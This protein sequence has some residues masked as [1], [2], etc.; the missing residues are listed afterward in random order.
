MIRWTFLFDISARVRRAHWAVALLFL[1]SGTTGA[2]TA[3]WTHSPPA[4]Q[5]AKPTAQLSVKGRQFPEKAGFGLF[6]VTQPPEVLLDGKAARLAPG[7]R[8]YGTDNLL[9][10]SG[11]LVGKTLAVAYVK[12]SYGLLHQVWLLTDAER[13]AASGAS[14]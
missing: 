1:A 7:A 4:H 8:I 5:V 3:P 2:D 11:T 13:K 10:L 14:S 6:H 12:D 9:L